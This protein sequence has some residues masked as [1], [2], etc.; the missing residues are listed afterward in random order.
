MAGATR[1][2]TNTAGSKG[3]PRAE[4]EAQILDVAAA[5]IARV[6]YAGLSLAVVATTAGVSKPL[7]YSYFGTKD[8]LY[9]ACQHRAAAVLGDAIDEALD[10]APSTLEMAQ[11]T[12]D[13]IFTALRPR[14]HDWK[15]VFDASHPTE[16]PVFEAAHDARARIAEQASRGVSAF[17]DDRG[18]FDPADRSALTAAWTGVVSAL[19]AWWLAHPEQSAEAMTARSHRLIAT[20][21]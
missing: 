1:A 10:G 20:L 2:R 3:V 19:V 8:G 13:A 12:L 11:R 15:V 9:L 17:L 7:V 16:G 14:P 6:G 5:E 21:T 18:L 4:R